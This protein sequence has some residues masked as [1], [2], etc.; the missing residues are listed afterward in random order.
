MIVVNE[1][2]ACYFFH[3]YCCFFFF[4]L[5]EKPKKSEKNGQLE[6]G[7]SLESEEKERTINS[8]QE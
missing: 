4:F 7:R 1:Y 5:F 6:Y 8:N 3:W 2:K